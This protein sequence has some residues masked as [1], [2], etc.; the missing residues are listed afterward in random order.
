MRFRK[1]LSLILA[2]ILALSVTGCTAGAPDDTGATETTA[3]TEPEI[4]TAPTEEAT[5]EST[6]ET[7][8]QVSRMP[9]QMEIPASDSSLS[10]KDIEI[11]ADAALVSMADDTL[12][13]APIKGVSAEPVDPY[14]PHYDV[15]TAGQLEG[16]PF[17]L[18]IFLDDSESRWTE[19]ELQTFLQEKFH[20]GIDWLCQQAS[21]WGVHL[22]YTAGYYWNYN[23][24]TCRYNGLVGDFNGDLKNDV[25][26]QAASSLG[27][28]SKEEMH[29][30][31]LEWSGK[32]QVAYVVILNKEGR[33]Y[34]M[35][36]WYNDGYDYMEY[37]VLFSKPSYVGDLV[38]DCPPATV[39]H[40]VLHLFGAEDYYSEGTQRVQR[41]QLASS[42]FYND[43]MLN[44]YCDISYN[45]V[46]AYTAYTVGW[47][48]VTPNV[49]YND[50]W[51]E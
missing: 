7:Q 51:W 30:S 37:C 28:T 50:G 31:M 42:Y 3:A 12:S 47:T 40:E 45:T 18:C 11:P 46:G 21:Y 14:R 10:Q 43:L 41:A 20:P 1:T 22:E 33:S 35:M 23:S 17:F 39:A 48:D 29:Q 25:L 6:E 13:P 32:D 38:Y 49:C 5:E 16:D 2:L 44:L 8:E 26:E 36:D 19:S 9:N 24:A 15:G 4:T 27:F 34:A